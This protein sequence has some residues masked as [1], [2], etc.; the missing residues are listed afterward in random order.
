[1]PNQISFVDSAGRLVAV[2]GYAPNWRERVVESYGWLTDVIEAYDGT[3]QRFALRD[4]PRRGLRYSLATLNQHAGNRLETLLLGW[5]SKLYA[6]PVWTDAQTLASDLPAGSLSAACDTAGY[7]FAVGDNALL[8]RA[9]DDYEALE[10]SAVN[11]GGLGFVLPTVASFPAGTRIL[12]IRLGRL[13]GAQKLERVTGR[14][15][16][17]EV[18]F[19]FEDNPGWAAADAGDTYLGYRVYP[20]RPNWA[21]RLDVEH[22]R[23]LAELDYLSGAAWRKDESGLA[24]LVKRWTWMHKSRADVVAFRTWLAARKGRL[25]PFWS[26]TQGD[27]ITVTTT[28]ASADISIQ[29]KNIGYQRLLNGRAD[30]RHIALRTKAGAVYYRQILGATEISGELETLTLDASL[31]AAV[32][33]DDIASL[34]FLHL[35]RLESDSIEIEWHHLSLAETTAAMRSLP[36]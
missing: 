22:V 4:A 2:F 29:I 35:T 6:V 17:G 32:N 19:A 11:A 20:L 21:G 16:Q 33:P 9:H 26:E 28:I 10:I 27:D 5:Q 7:E 12:P 3:E 1:M 30:R 25:V 23:K 31:G 13:P 14:H 24:N 34:R 8:W 18:A 15:F 36:Q